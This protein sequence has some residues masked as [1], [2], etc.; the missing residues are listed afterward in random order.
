MI[1]RNIIIIA[2]AIILAAPSGWALT[3]IKLLT[4]EPG[5]RPTGMGGAFTAIAADPYS[6]AFNP[7][8]SYGIGPLSGSFGHN[9]YWEN[10]GIETGY[11]SFKK[12][13]I[14]YS[15]GIQ[16]A[17]ANDLQGRGDV[18]SDDY[19]SFD[20]ND[21]MFKM[22]AAFKIDKDIVF[23]L[24]LGWIYEKI[25][26][27]HGSSFNADFGILAH[28]LNNVDFGLAI[29][30]LGGKMKIREAEYD[31]PTAFRAGISYKYNKLLAA[32][33]VVVQ[34]DETHLHLGGE[35]LIKQ[36]L[37]LRAGYRM[38]YDTKDISAGIG[39]VHRNFRFDYAFIPYKD[40]LGDSH[41][42]NINFHL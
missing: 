18:P 13:G 38:G 7:A 34:D 17:A 41:L 10:I 37:Y 21:L 42:I 1:K 29:Q 16:F 27:Y 28:P 20:A 5:A 36:V 33:D 14:T 2:I 30:N 39:F 31:L 9:A 3:G 15:A 24:M 32:G 19:Y 12:K 25:E 35:Y 6:S 23:G 11:I 40:N 26:Q 22:G 8:A 4:V